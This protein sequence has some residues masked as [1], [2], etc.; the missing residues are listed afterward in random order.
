MQPQYKSGA[1][2]RK[3]R[4]EPE[5]RDEKGA[6]PADIWVW[7]NLIS[8]IKRKK[9]LLNEDQNEY[10][11][12]NEARIRSKSSNQISVAVIESDAN[13][14]VSQPPATWGDRPKAMTEAE[15][16]ASTSQKTNP[17]FNNDVGSWPGKA[18]EEMTDFW[19]QQGSEEC[20][21]LQ[22]EY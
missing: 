6:M 4:A 9:P 8:N 22:K 15:S 7:E 13:V 12:T 3:C 17:L 19:A 2:K 14:N 16:K 11:K 20:Q 21:H 10:I 1:A 18:T 5:K